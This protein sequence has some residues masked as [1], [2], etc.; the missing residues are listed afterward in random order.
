MITIL[1]AGTHVE[2]HY[3]LFPFLIYRGTNRFAITRDGDDALRRG[4][5][6]TGRS[7]ALVILAK[8]YEAQPETEQNRWFE[9]FRD[10]FDRIVFVDDSDSP[11]S[12]HYSL[13]SVIDLFYQKQLLRDRSQYETEFTGNRLFCDY[14]AR[15]YGLAND[16][17]ERYPR[18][19]DPSQRK[20]LRVLWNLGYG[21]YPL[22]RTPKK[23]MERVFT[24]V[25]GYR[26][27]RPLLTRPRFRPFEA[28][29][30]GK[31]HARFGAGGYR[32]LVAY[33]RKLFL[34]RVT[35]DPLFLSGRVP[36][37][38][39]DREL[40]SVQAVL[41]PFGWGELCYRD[42]EAFIGGN[43]LIKPDVSH[44]E[45]WPDVFTADQTYVSVKWNGSDL[46]DR[47]HEVLSNQQE[48][49]RI[50][51]TAQNAYR[52]AF[53]KIDERVDLFCEEVLA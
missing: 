45:T 35:D 41:S 40:R 3:T 17:D 29:S 27:I 12:K 18:I 49:K 25:A 36:R 19:T 34:D 8:W 4:A 33:Q 37:A 16:T 22:F 50:S 43:V 30:T 1:T 39:Y 9:R 20:K 21:Q 53:E 44:L 26:G 28:L 13:L 15:E 48:M 14:Y 7:S 32:P 6:R 31:C 5:S 38:E 46:V 2:T 23:A 24:F 10:L 47:T 11:H 52:S 42:F 51:A